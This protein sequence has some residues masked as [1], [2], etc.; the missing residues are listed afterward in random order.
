MGRIWREAMMM[1]RHVS[2]AKDACAELWLKGVLR[3]HNTGDAP[4]VRFRV[5]QACS[6][7]NGRTV[8]FSR[9]ARSCATL[10][11]R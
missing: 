1:L 11:L 6:L 9:E 5:L 8:V 4:N 7:S 2:Q 3:D 10:G